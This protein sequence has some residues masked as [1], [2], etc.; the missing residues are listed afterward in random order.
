MN[1]YCYV[2]FLAHGVPVT[3]IA[4]FSESGRRSQSTSLTVSCSKS[5]WC[6][7]PPV[8]VGCNIRP[9]RKLRVYG[10]RPSIL[11]VTAAYQNNSFGQEAAGH[12][13]SSKPSAATWQK[14]AAAALGLAVLAGVV[15]FPTLAAAGLIDDT[16]PLFAE[17]SRQML[18]TGDWITP[19]FNGQPRFDKP[20]LIYWLMAA[21][22]LVWG[23]L[24]LSDMLLTFTMTAA[25]LSFFRAY[26][27][28]MARHHGYA[29]AALF[30]A[31]AVLTKGPVG[32]VLPAA[33][34][35]LFLLY[36]GELWPF[37]KRELPWMSVLLTFVGVAGPW[38]AAMARRHGAMYLATFFG[39]HNF[40][41]F[42]RGVNHHGGQPW[43]FAP[44]I[45]LVMYFP[46][47]LALPAVAARLQ[48]WRPSERAKWRASQRRDRLELFAAAWAVTS[49]GIFAMSKSQLPQ[50]YLPMAPAV[51]LLVGAQLS[52]SHY[53][54]EGE[55]GRL[56][57]RLSTAAYALLAGLMA[58]LPRLVCATSPDPKA[59]EIATRVGAARL[60]V[61]AAALLGLAALLAATSAFHTRKLQVP[62]Q[63]QQL[64]PVELPHLLQLKEQRRQQLSVPLWAVQAL[65]M[66]SLLAGFVRPVY[67]QA[68]GVLQAP[69]RQVAMLAGSVRGKGEALLMLGPRMPSAVFYSRQPVAFVESAE[70]ALHV[71]RHQSPPWLQS[72]LVL[73]EEE[74]LLAPALLPHSVVVARR[75]SACLLRVDL[76]TLRDASVPGGAVELLPSS[77]NKPDKQLLQA[78]HW[79][80]SS[81]GSFM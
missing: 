16:E 73:T 52:H 81:P 6:P 56:E 11:L 59:V 8:R 54:Q 58:C 66:A 32:L 13:T 43:W 65:L 63:K 38:Y 12:N 10:T 69:M 53:P 51:G 3:R 20:P 36:T 34:C 5:L 57:A 21:S 48:L 23:S 30:C 22:A 18:L 74:R 78:E 64:Q 31:L 62:K 41:R 76:R 17:A 27:G 26:S 42:A 9:L 67:R 47:S 60:H 29:Q 4:G 25:G 33:A 75:G 2:S 68:D 72:V 24:G 45:V 79:T 46:W 55:G 7:I 71:L 14:W 77:S 1:A 28:A 61:V 37:L 70:E 19:Q 50:Y 80:F 40:E 49:L 15:Y 39:Y 44:A 35:G